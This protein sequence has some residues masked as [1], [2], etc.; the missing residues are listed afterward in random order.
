[1]LKLYPIE[2][3]Y[4]IVAAL[5]CKYILLRLRKPIKV[6]FL[7]ADESIPFLDAQLYLGDSSEK[8]VLPLIGDSFAFVPSSP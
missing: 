6:D 4:S 2:A 7:S 8:T 1:M 5:P 3:L